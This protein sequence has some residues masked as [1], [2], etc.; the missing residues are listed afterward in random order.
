MLAALQRRWGSSRRRDLLSMH[1]RPMRPTQAHS[2]RRAW[3][4]PNQYTQL[5][6][7]KE[8]RQLSTSLRLSRGAAVVRRTIPIQSSRSQPRPPRKA[9]R[10]LTQVLLGA[11]QQLL[12]ILSR[13]EVASKHN[14]SLV[15]SQPQRVL[16]QL[17]AI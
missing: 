7:R 14:P 13:Q 8:G 17:S 15:S 11:T 6:R 9:L 10:L 16:R 2:N 12:R 3:G 4:W 1:F 5:R